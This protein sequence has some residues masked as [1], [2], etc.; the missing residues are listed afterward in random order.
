MEV[1]LENLNKIDELLII[2]KEIAQSST[3]HHEKIWLSVKEL[4]KYLD[5]SVDRIHKLKGTEFIENDHYFKSNGKL[6]FKKRRIN[7]WV[8]GIGRAERTNGMDVDSFIEEII[9]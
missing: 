3:S 5:Y 6:L 8:Q 4:A 7:D 9:K 1:K 2:V